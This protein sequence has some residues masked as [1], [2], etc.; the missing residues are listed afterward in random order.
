[1]MSPTAHTPMPGACQRMRSAPAPSPA[2]R[3][4]A[5]CSQDGL[6]S[7]VTAFLEDVARYDG[8]GQPA[9]PACAGGGGAQ[10]VAAQARLLQCAFLRLTA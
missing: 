2:R 5:V 9:L 3:S 8:S 4:R 1:M 6:H 10:T 7:R